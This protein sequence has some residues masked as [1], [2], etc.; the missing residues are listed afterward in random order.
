MPYENWYPNPHNGPFPDS[1]VITH[2]K[3]DTIIYEEPTV[4]PKLRTEPRTNN[5]A[6]QILCIHHKKSPIG[7]ETYTE[8]M[9]D[10][11]NTL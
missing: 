6:I 3:A 7:T 8:Q 2:F 1:H 5:R 4:P 9:K 10:T 11:T